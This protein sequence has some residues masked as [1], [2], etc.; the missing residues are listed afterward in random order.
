MPY[1]GGSKAM[2]KSFDTGIRKIRFWVRYVP[3][4]GV[5]AMP[6]RSKRAAQK[7]KQPGEILVQVEGLYA[8]PA[9]TRRGEWT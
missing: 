6:Y 1:L 3:R 5:E 2:G 8:E 9:Q 7:E 4:K